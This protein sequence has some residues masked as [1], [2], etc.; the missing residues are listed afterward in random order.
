MK[1]SRQVVAGLLLLSLLLVGYGTW[2]TVRAS[3]LK[4]QLSRLQ[5][6]YQELQTKHRA[7]AGALLSTDRVR[8]AQATVDLLRED[9]EVPP[10]SVSEARPAISEVNAVPQSP[11]SK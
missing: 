11:T 1:Q 9:L 3:R 5:V 2:T 4:Q 7:L 6:S 8:V 10:T